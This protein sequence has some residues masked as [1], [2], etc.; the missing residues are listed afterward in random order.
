MDQSLERTDNEVSFFPLP[1][2]SLTNENRLN[3]VFIRCH[4]FATSGGRSV[5]HRRFERPLMALN[6]Q[7]QHFISHF[8]PRAIHFFGCFY[9]LL[10]VNTHTPIC[11]RERRDGFVF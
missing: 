5:S 9:F 6:D 10:F 1:L 3:D 4:P 8:I 7:Q 2:V 11:Q